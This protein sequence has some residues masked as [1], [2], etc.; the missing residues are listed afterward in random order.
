[1]SL[2]SNIMVLKPGIY[3]FDC[4]DRCHVQLDNEVSFCMKLI[5]R[6]RSEVLNNLLVDGYTGL[7]PDK[8]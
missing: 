2:H 1:M 3:D 6:M 4:G 7:G 8:A 5:S